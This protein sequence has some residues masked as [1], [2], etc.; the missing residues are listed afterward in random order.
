MSGR[1][2]FRPARAGDGKAA[3]EVTV[4][5]IR[6]FGNDHYSPEQIDGWMGG[7]TADFYEALIANGRTTIAE[8][9]G[10]VVGFV[11]A[12]PGE[13]T[14]LFVLPQEAGS[15]LGGRLLR[16]GIETAR[17]GHCGPLRVEATLNA[18]GFYRRHGFRRIGPA[19]FSHGLGG[20]RIE[21][22]LMEL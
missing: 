17:V 20:P 2:T 3:F 9:D 13:L 7:R 11:D 21:V 19:E 4:W 1:W 15:G 8:R 18:E 14:R 5:A 12:E 22:V 16:V 10:A 6:A